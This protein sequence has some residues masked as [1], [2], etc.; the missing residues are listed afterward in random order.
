M[1]FLISDFLGTGFE[2]NIDI[3]SRRHDLIAVSITDPRELEI[4]NVGLL[5]LEDAETGELIVIDTGSAEVR[6]L[7]EQSGQERM[8]K[9]KELF[10]SIGVDQ[11]DVR[12]NQDYVRNLIHFFLTRERRKAR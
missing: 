5:E 7:Y 2:R 4:P 11:I 6:E 9:L 12:T 1:V 3:T 10:G 8:K